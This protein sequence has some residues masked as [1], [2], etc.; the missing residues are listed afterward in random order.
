MLSTCMA[1]ITGRAFGC[2]QSFLLHFEHELD[3][4]RWADGLQDEAEREAEGGAHAEDGDR[5]G[6]VEKRL[7]QARDEQQ[8]HGCHPDSLEDLAAYTRTVSATTA[9]R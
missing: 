9:R 6:A 2:A 4:Q 1:F 3:D 8:L 7:S 5:D